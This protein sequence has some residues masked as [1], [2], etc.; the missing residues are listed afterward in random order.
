MELKTQGITWADLVQAA[1]SERGSLAE[2]VRTL[3]ELHPSRL[4]DDPATVERG[5]RRLRKRGHAPADKYGRLILRSFGLPQEMQAY[6]ADLGTYHSALMDLP[7]QAR[8]AQLRLWDRNPVLES[9]Q[10]AWIHLGMAS[11]AHHQGRLEDAHRRLQLAALG[12]RRAGPSASIEHGLFSARLASDA[13]EAVRARLEGLL[14]SVE[15]LPVGADQ[16]CYHARVL[17]QLAYDASR[18]GG[19]EGLKAALQL[20]RQIPSEGPAFVRFRRAFGLAW[21]LNKL[22]EPEALQQGELALQI[23]GDAGL[24]RLRAGALGLL[25]KLRPEEAQSF[26]SRQAEILQ[27]LC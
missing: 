24:L 23:A 26:R 20:R 6:A 10:G 12:L 17:D 9:A 1:V 13:G 8:S 18:D 15:Q 7:L 19:T 14:E 5:L 11:L 2:V 25:A 27:R 21:T 3:Y 4:P 16:A 22:G